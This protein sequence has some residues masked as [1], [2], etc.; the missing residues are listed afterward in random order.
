ME[1]IMSPFLSS[2]FPWPGG[3]TEKEG[4]LPTTNCRDKLK[5]WRGA[6]IIGEMARPLRI[7]Q[8]VGE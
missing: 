5:N 4:G 1:M 3:M 8:I 7:W 2:G 6:G